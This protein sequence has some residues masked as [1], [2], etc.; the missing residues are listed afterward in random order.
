MS[1]PSRVYFVIDCRS[2]YASVEAFDRGLDPLT[3]DLVV[4]DESRTEK[5]ICLAVSPHLKA[6]GV[7][8]RC[9]L[10]DVP[11]DDSIVIAK[12][13]MRR[14]I[15]ICAGIY[16]IYLKYISKEDIHVYSID[17]VI[18]DVTT[19]L[20][21]YKMRA[22]EF[23]LKLMN[24]IRDTYGIP[25]TAGI[26]TNMYLAKVASGLLAKH[27][28]QGI[29]WLNEE[30]FIKLCS[31]T[32]PL[33]SFWMISGGIESH[34]ARLGIFDMEGIRNADENMLYEEFGVNAE[35]LIDHAY[36][37]EPTRM[38]DI[39]SYKAS[40]R[41]ISTNQILPSA[42]SKADAKTILMEMIEAHSLELARRGL[43]SSRL[44]VMV[45]FDTRWRGGSGIHYYVDI[46]GKGNLASLFMPLACELYYKKVPADKGVRAIALSFADVSEEPPQSFS[47]FDDE[48]EIAREKNLRDSLLLIEQRYGKNAV[49]K[50]HD[51]TKSATARERNVMIGGHN[52]GDE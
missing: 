20:R 12:P 9:R 24:E 32:R 27:D 26:G 31:K 2:F 30:R 39:K 46:A 50:A 6:R 45:S 33:S 40:S 43:V 10:F 19:Y 35:I 29:A 18:I 36:G 22:K 11:K 49:L 16:G 3:V 28:P 1:E 38:S 5:T 17:E 14:Y 41:G 37:R 21:L 42:Y 7:K 13:R 52:G 47:L 34:L 51:F 44:A 23:A 48:D 15:E 4:A 25:T 8:N